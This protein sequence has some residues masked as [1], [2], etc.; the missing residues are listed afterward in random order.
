MVPDLWRLPF[1]SKRAA[2]DGKV[3]P[4]MT[5]ATANQLADPD[6]K[7]PHKRT[8]RMRSAFVMTS[9]ELMLIAALAII[10]LS[11]KPRAG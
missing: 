2:K 4:S 1:F 11:S 3:R 10:G 6:S 9:T 5:S 8:L 7:T